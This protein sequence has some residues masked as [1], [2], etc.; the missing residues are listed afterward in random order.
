MEKTF[1]AEYESVTGLRSRLNIPRAELAGAISYIKQLGRLTPG[2]YVIFCQEGRI[3]TPVHE[4]T[5]EKPVAP[6]REG[7]TVGMARIADRGKMK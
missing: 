2:S 3:T 7:G 6:A 1:F 4:E 5:F